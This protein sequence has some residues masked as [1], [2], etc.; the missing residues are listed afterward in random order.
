MAPSTSHS[1]VS[2]RNSSHRVKSSTTSAY[3][4]GGSSDGR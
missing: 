4:R 2:K 1:T 3:S